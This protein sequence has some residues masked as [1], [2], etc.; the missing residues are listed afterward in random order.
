MSIKRVA[1][2]YGVFTVFALLLSIFTHPISVN[3]DMK[4]F[5]DKEIMLERSEIKTFLIFIFTSATIYLFAVNI[6]FTKKKDLQLKP[7]LSTFLQ[8][9][10]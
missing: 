2:I 4:L 1:N 6:Y 9:K 8:S 3:E 10:Q 7:L 5:F